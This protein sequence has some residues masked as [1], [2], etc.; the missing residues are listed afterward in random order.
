[1][2]I[3]SPTVIPSISIIAP[4]LFTTRHRTQIIYSAV[5]ALPHTIEVFL[6][7]ISSSLTELHFLRAADKK[8]IETMEG[9]SMVSLSAGRAFSNTSLGSKC[10]P[11]CKTSCEEIW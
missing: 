5:D 2:A 8:S 6:S 11:A 3:I 1:M 9:R 10:N 4:L 7:I